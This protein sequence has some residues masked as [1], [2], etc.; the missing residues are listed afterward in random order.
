MLADVN[1]STTLKSTTRVR[2]DWNYNRVV[3][4]ITRPGDVIMHKAPDDPVAHP[5]YVDAEGRSLPVDS[6]TLQIMVNASGHVVDKNGN[7][8]PSYERPGFGLVHEDDVRVAVAARDIVAENE[9][10]EEVMIAP[11]GSIIPTGDDGLPNVVMV[12]GV[13][14]ATDAYGNPVAPL[15]SVL[16][17]GTYHKPVE[18]SNW[19]MD[20]ALNP[21]ELIE[22]NYG[23][24]FPIE[25]IVEPYRPRRRGALKA[26]A[27]ESGSKIS[28][29]TGT[30]EYQQ[31]RFYTADED[32]KYK[33]WTPDEP[34]ASSGVITNGQVMPM[35]DG[36]W[37]S[38][39]VSSIT[40]T[41][42]Q[43]SGNFNYVLRGGNPYIRREFDM[44]PG[45]SYTLDFSLAAQTPASIVHIYLEE[46]G[47]L[48]VGGRSRLIHEYRTSTVAPEEKSITFVTSNNASH[49]FIRIEVV[50]SRINTSPRVTISNMEYG[51]TVYP[52]AQVGPRASYDR[53][54]PVNKIVIG[55]DYTVDERHAESA[56]NMPVD[57]NVMARIE[58]SDGV[59]EW[60]VVATDV[61]PNDDGFIEL[62]WDG[63]N[64]TDEPSWAGETV[65]VSA[66]QF[67][68][69]AM[70]MPGARVNITEI[71]AHMILDLSDRLHSYD[72]D[73]SV[74]DDSFVLPFGTVTSNVGTLILSN[75]DGMFNNDNPFLLDT[76]RYSDGEFVFTDEINPLYGLLNGDITFTVDTEVHNPDSIKPEGWEPE[77]IRIFT[78]S[79]GRPEV[80][81]DMTA[82]FNLKDSS[83]I[84]QQVS[85]NR[86]FYTDH[87]GMSVMQV[88]YMLLDSI[89]FTHLRFDPNDSFEATHMKYYWTNEE[90][91]VWE[92]L[93]DICRSAQVTAYFD[94]YDIL[95]LRS[96]RAVYEDALHDPPKTILT[97]DDIGDLKSNV[98]EIEDGE[99]FQTN[100]VVVNYKELKS[101]E[102]T[103]S[104]VAKM[105]EV[106]SPEG[107][108][109]LRSQPL[110]LAVHGESMEQTPLQSVT[111]PHRSTT[112]WP[113]EGLINIEG[114]LIRY[115]GKE[116]L[117]KDRN[118]NTGY[119]ICHT[120][121][122]RKRL[123]KLNPDLSYK[124]FWTGKLRTA[125]RGA[126][127]TLVR[128][129]GLGSTDGYGVW[130]KPKDAPRVGNKSGVKFSDSKV[131]LKAPAIPGRS[132]ES[133]YLMSRGSPH[134]YPPQIFGT[135]LNITGGSN[136]AGMAIGVN[137]N[138]EG[139][140]IELNT[141][142]QVE[143]LDRKRNELTIYLL[144]GGKRTYLGSN[145]QGIV[146]PISKNKFYDLQVTM[147]DGVRIRR[148]YLYRDYEHITIQK[149]SRGTAVKVLQQGLN[150]D[151]AEKLV[152]DGVCGNKT[153]AAIKRAQKRSGITQ[154]GVVNL[155]D[156][157][158][159]GSYV[160]QPDRVSFHVWL[161][162]VMSH[163]AVVDKSIL[164]TGY[165]GGSY[166]MF[167]RSTT[168]AEFE[169]LYGLRGSEELVND[170]DNGLMSKIT[171]SYFSDQINNGYFY[172]R[173]YRY[174]IVGGKKVLREVVNDQFF[175]DDFG[176]YAH[177][178]R[179]FNIDFDDLERPAEYSNLYISNDMA[180][181]V[182]D[183]SHNPFGAKF[184]IAN[185]ARHDAILNGEDPI[186]FGIDESVDQKMLIY[187]RVLHEDSERR[188]AIEDRN[189]TRSRGINELS[190]DVNWI[191]STEAA[192]KLGS[193]IV[194]AMSQPVRTFMVD[195][196]G[197]PYLKI[198]D[199][200]IL[201]APTHGVSIPV[202][203]TLSNDALMKSNR[204]IVTGVAHSNDG[205]HRTTLTV[206]Q[207]IDR[208]GF[209]YVRLS[210]VLEHNNNNM[211]RN[212]YLDEWE[213]TGIIV[214]PKDVDARQNTLL[215]W[216]AE[217]R[218]KG[219]MLVRGMPDTPP[220]NYKTVGFVPKNILLQSGARPAH[221]IGDYFLWTVDVIAK[222]DC[223]IAMHIGGYQTSGYDRALAEQR[224]RLKK[225]RHYRCTIQGQYLTHGD[226]PELMPMFFLLGYD[227][228]AGTKKEI[229][230]VY[231]MFYRQSNS[232]DHIYPTEG[233][234]TLR[235]P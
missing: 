57:N 1:N 17:L 206:R 192:N 186:T 80:N 175:F 143:A 155:D 15:E 99:M 144:K 79:A 212:Q 182:A 132:A 22:Q 64:W 24:L 40:L 138:A 11:D 133:I 78:M 120:E 158:A 191:Q 73:F 229:V 28:S 50:R 27:T 185:T 162:G 97:T 177:E 190:I 58:R 20:E 114:E 219:Y 14:W 225:G 197:N 29:Y 3:A 161:D 173:K 125:E 72:T 220:A 46:H 61:L 39:N 13:P 42:G 41:S 71:S 170:G 222:S 74:A 90:G 93:E 199:M 141:T 136:C 34:A 83:Q 85:P 131:T 104:G 44:E 118:G 21:V 110:R 218:G 210:D 101:A 127:G 151:W 176:A 149:G 121:E 76:E 235:R 215:Q 188:V 169:Y 174:R 77:W 233:Y 234:V 60:Q 54:L 23:D 52:V 194:E 117:F 152:V 86:L 200:V 49:Y 108:V 96:L 88:I 62:Y 183:Y 139:I 102:I 36:G 122:E 8:V 7:Y 232:P 180:A 87:D 55:V 10:D 48:G 159:L 208:N 84:L 124:N 123:D 203:E 12:E 32:S 198:G 195:A 53:P 146:A 150:R 209:R 100:R 187:G 16:P 228:Q 201:Y 5:M 168:T 35:G 38:H 204:Y 130:F 205:T 107:D 91:T 167:V 30:G 196:F 105:E 163:E 165:D 106:W 111:L 82:T 94:E 109:V 216:K 179:D 181:L 157:R 67:N 9:N 148:E 172:T 227:G 103:E 37:Q 217:G 119:R 112:T 128:P 70:N 18:A 113:F 223:T 66:V 63:S 65:N 4:S 89:G 129:H 184:R 56:S 116:Y 6:T 92:A 154:S 230:E 214:V 160:V 68:A 19:P 147:F 43:F 231:D 153:V 178:V 207:L 33:Y 135:R 2:A 156:W 189:S 126:E 51:Q 81:Y 193:H 202:D 142:E 75:H 25:S 140:Y 45:T 226:V 134:S 145:P 164:N 115:R 213:S 98:I 137:S 171:G 59:Q 69:W 26:W 221:N 166:G 211:L 224:F 95:N 31:G 47:A